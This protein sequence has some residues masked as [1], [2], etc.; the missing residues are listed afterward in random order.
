MPVFQGGFWL[1]KWS[2]LAVSTL[3]VRDVA[4]L[5]LTEVLLWKT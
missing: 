1:V 5:P 2:K 3:S 4:C